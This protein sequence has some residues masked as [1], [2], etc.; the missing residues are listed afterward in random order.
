MSEHKGLSCSQCS[1]KLTLL[2]SI[3]KNKPLGATRQLAIYSW[4]SGLALIAQTVIQNTAQLLTCGNKQGKSGVRENQIKVAKLEE[5]P[6]LI[7][8]EYLGTNWFHEL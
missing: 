4:H 6:C 2:I 5:I 7:L 8:D 3:W 1:I